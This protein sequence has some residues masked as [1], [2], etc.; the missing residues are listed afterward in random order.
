MRNF[1]MTPTDTQRI[2]Q[3][4]AE[5]AKLRAE[6]A[7]LKPPPRV[8]RLG[9]PF[10]PPDTVQTAQLTRIVLARFPILHPDNVHL[11]PLPMDKYVPM[12]RAGMIYLASLARMRGK[13]CR[14]RSYMDWLLLANIHLNQVGTSPST[15]LGSSLFVAAIATNEVP[16]SPPRLW[17][18]TADMGVE[19]GA[20]GSPATNR[21]LALLSGSD[22]DPSLIVE[23]PAPLHAPRQVYETA[24]HTNW[25]AE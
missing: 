25:R 14:V 2:V 10:S 22:F 4:E 15:L 13:V 24:G 21:W 1:P 18:Q 6:V 16:Y 19:V 5:N 17:P 9:D 23:P 3:L 12:V 8:L 20:C 11:D 7:R